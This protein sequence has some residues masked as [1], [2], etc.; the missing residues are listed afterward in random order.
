MY[1]ILAV[2]GALVGLSFLLVL[3]AEI[4]EDLLRNANRPVSFF[5]KSAPGQGQKPVEIASV[6]TCKGER[7]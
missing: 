5:T 3:A 1:T 6:S 7:L 2:L 4:A